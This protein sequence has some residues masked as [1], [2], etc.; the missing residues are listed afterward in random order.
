MPAAAATTNYGCT[1]TTLDTYV[2]VRIFA[3]ICMYNQEEW[4]VA[5]QHYS[6]TWASSNHPSIDLFNPP[7]ALSAAS[8]A[9]THPTATTSPTPSGTEGGDGD[10]QDDGSASKYGGGGVRVESGV[11]IA[12]ARGL[13]GHSAT[14]V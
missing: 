3:Y 2:R 6:L 7:P 4:A 12:G 1:T 9:H 14:S 8:A 10:G 13:F 5:C 11:D